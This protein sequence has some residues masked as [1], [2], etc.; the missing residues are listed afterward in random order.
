MTVKKTKIMGEYDEFDLLILKELR[1]NCKIP[2]RILAGKT[3]LHPNTLMQRV[4]RLE[5]NRI[6]VKYVA[7]MDYSKL[8][9]D[10]HALLMIKVDKKARSDWSVLENLKAMRD[11]LALYTITG[12]YD[13]CAIIKTRDRESLTRL[14]E[15][16]NKS[17]YVVETNTTF[18]LSAV[19]HAYEFNPFK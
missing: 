17:E 15:N 10:L 12:V 13:L 5:N 9:Y 18:M 8:N 19:K 16:I 2:I 6:I 4:K 11:I 3:G 7:E 14:I 1:E